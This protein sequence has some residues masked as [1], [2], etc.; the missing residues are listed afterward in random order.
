MTHCN[1]AFVRDSL[2][3]NNE[4]IESIVIYTDTISLHYQYHKE[5]ITM[6]YYERQT[7]TP[8]ISKQLPKQTP[9][10]NWCSQVYKWTIA[11]PIGIDILI[12]CSTMQTGYLQ[13]SCFPLRHYYMSEVYL[14]I[15][16]FIKNI[17]HLLLL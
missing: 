4:S 15:E 16:L 11:G 12:L 6:L 13:C 10:S 2:Q 17:Y 7:F 3:L 8:Y 9:Q 14:N 1:V 5:L